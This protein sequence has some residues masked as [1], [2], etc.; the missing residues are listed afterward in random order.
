MS[1]SPSAGR[2]IDKGST[3]T[4]TVARQPKE[5][6]VPDVTGE[7]QS[8]AVQRLS[9]EGFEIEVVEQPVG[10]QEDDGVVIEQDPAGGK[11]RRGSTVTI[12]VSRFDPSAAPGQSAPAPAT[13]APATPAP[14][15]P[16]QPSTP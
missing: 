13:P 15:T 8:K 4:L 12:T 3:I 10:T 6:E 5:V 2:K 1:Q 7:K 9:R 11:A 14:P 16:A